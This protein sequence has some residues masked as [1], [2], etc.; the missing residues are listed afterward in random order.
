MARPEQVASMLNRLTDRAFMDALSTRDQQSMS[1][2]IAEFFCADP[3]TE[4]EE[5]EDLGK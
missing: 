1:D 5:E 2:L 4:D 3:E